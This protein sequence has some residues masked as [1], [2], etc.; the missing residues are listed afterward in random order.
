MTNGTHFL[1]LKPLLAFDAATCAAMGTILLIG[2]APIAGLT[3]IPVP[4]LFGAGVCLVPIAVFMAI[5]SHLTPVPGWVAALV[6]SGNLLWAAASM[7]LP[8]TGLISPSALGWAF[9]IGQA[10][11]VVILSK[12]EF[13]ALRARGATSDFPGLKGGMS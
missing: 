2:S 9:L 4:L 12:L 7:L 10:A 13:Y 5:S 11:I 1:S 8:S 3:G 6:I